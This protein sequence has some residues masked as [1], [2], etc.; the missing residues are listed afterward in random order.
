MRCANDT[1]ACDEDVGKSHKILVHQL[2]HHLHLHQQMHFPLFRGKINVLDSHFVSTFDF[3]AKEDCASGPRAQLSAK[4][5]DCLQLFG[6]AQLFHFGQ[7]L[8]VGKQRY[9]S[10]GQRFILFQDW[11]DSKITQSNVATLTWQLF[12]GLSVEGSLNW[13]LDRLGGLLGGLVELTSPL[14][15]KPFFNSKMASVMAF[16]ASVSW[17]MWKLFTSSPSP[18][19]GDSG[20]D[21]SAGSEVLSLPSDWERLRRM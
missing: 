13:T 21:S 14:E 3:S 19:L 9:V 15:S 18:W 1:P 16:W 6:V 2:P 20:S 10:I 5:E 12:D 7:G 17:T 11:N 4:L 8:L